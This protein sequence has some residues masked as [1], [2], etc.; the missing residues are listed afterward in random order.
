MKSFDILD[1]TG[2]RRK[3]DGHYHG[4]HAL[5]LEG[6]IL[7]E[8]DDGLTVGVSLWEKDIVSHQYDIKRASLDIYYQAPPKGTIRIAILPMS[9]FSVPK[10]IEEINVY[11]AKGKK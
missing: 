6:R 3:L 1:L 4:K 8:E 7:A 2:Q 9:E 5:H 11:D 10:D